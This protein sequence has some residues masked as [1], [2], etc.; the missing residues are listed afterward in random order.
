[1]IWA[2]HLLYGQPPPGVDV[3]TSLDLDLQQAADSLLAD[4]KG[5]LVLLNAQSGE[6]LAMASHPTFNANR[7][8]EIGQN[9]LQN[10]NSPLLNRATQGLY[11][12]GAALGPLLLA[13]SGESKAYL[14]CLAS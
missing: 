6:I 5:A 9:L 10:P 14:P 1:M 8:S 7:L 3:R 11:P 12:A 13:D 4:Q 2:S